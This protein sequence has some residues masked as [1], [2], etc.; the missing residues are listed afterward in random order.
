[1]TTYICKLC[2]ARTNTRKE[3]DEHVRDE[4]MPPYK[5]RKVKRG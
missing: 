4:H 1:M 3:L 5:R 2:P